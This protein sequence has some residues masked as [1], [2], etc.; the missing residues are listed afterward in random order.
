MMVEGPNV[1]DTTASSHNCLTVFA[2]EGLVLLGMRYA[3]QG[4]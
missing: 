3:L 2:L 1:A 4:V